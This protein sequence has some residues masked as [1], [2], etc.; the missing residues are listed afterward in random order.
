MYARMEALRARHPRTASEDLEAEA[1]RDGF[2]FP[3]CSPVKRIDFIL[4]RNHSSVSGELSVSVVT[5]RIVG[6]KPPAD[7]GE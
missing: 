3:A 6:S 4:V 2:T 7:T 1:E 5:S